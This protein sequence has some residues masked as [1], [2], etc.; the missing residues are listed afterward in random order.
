MSNI[1]TLEVRIFGKKLRKSLFIPT[2]IKPT[3]SPAKNSLVYFISIACIDRPGLRGHCQE[4]KRGE[5]GGPRITRCEALGSFLL[6]CATTELSLI[7]M[8]RLS[9]VTPRGQPWT[10][11]VTL[12]QGR[13]GLIARRLA[14]FVYVSRALSVPPRAPRINAQRGAQFDPYNTHNCLPPKKLRPEIQ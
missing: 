1:F 8:W 2:L 5:A 11:A 3:V 14:V 6:P 10:P 12:P 9:G 4:A 13:D 7:T